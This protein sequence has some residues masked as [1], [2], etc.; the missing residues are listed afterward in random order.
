MAVLLPETSHP[1]GVR[2]ADERGLPAA[3]LRP[4]SFRVRIVAEPKVFCRAPS[5]GASAR[6]PLSVRVRALDT[7]SSD[8][9]KAAGRV[10]AVPDAAGTAAAVLASQAANLAY[11][12]SRR[13]SM[14]EAG[15]HGK[16][17]A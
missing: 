1:T 13:P 3:F 12:L 2:L 11:F 15:H 10:S 4:L 9:S 8:V 5:R 7:S 17:R 6:M 14:L 16:F